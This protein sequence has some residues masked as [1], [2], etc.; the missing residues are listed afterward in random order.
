MRISDLP[1]KRAS[2]ARA[3]YRSRAL[4]A[5]AWT[6]GHSVLRVVPMS[7]RSIV[8]LGRLD[9]LAARAPA[10]RYAT[11]SPVPFDGFDGEWV[12]A[13]TANDDA[14][15]L[16]FHGGGFFFC[17]LN[18]HRRG[19]ARISATSGLPVL[20]V[21]YRQ[22]PSTPI[23][24]SIADC[25]TAY[26]HLLDTGVPADKIVFAGDSAGG[27]LAFATAMRAR[28]LDLPLPAGIVATSPLLDIDS[29]A[30]LGHPN[31]RRESYIPVNRLAQLTALWTGEPGVHEPPLS[32][33]NEDPSGLPPSLI[34]A[35]ESEILRVDSEVMAERL[36]AAGV[37]CKLQIWP[38]QVHAFPVLGNLTPETKAAVNQIAKFIREVTKVD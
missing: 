26:R 37:P 32:P 24:G 23:P 3:S 33:V 8:L 15:V 1:G 7:P 17:G 13:K 14:A 19:V 35:A 34:I 20:S 30:R 36:W 9:R 27:Y 16:Y 31:M 25:V 28:D 4:Y 11:M 10:P 29:T 21:A 38:G 22:L 5:A 18:T 12:R 6:A 2:R